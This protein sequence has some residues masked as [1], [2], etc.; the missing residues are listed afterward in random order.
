M[1]YA[2]M[3]LSEI[4]DEINRKALAL[5]DFVFSGEN[6]SEHDRMLDYTHDLVDACR[7]ANDLARQAFNPASPPE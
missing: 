2:S 1:K 7:A 4:N 5:S 3:S 6:L